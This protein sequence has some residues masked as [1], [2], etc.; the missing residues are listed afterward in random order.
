MQNHLLLAYLND[1]KYILK[2]KYYLDYLLQTIIDRIDKF[3]G[4]SFKFPENRSYFGRTGNSLHTHGFCPEGGVPKYSM[5][6]LP[7]RFSPLAPSNL[8]PTSLRRS[9]IVHDIPMQDEKEG[10]DLILGNRL[11]SSRSETSRIIDNDDFEM[12][13]DVFYRLLRQ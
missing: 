5:Y 1:Q 2:I 12:K 6:G 4:V 8:Y 13:Q 10:G 9:A 3:T 7:M 11:F